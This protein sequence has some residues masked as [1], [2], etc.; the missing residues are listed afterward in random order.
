M[1]VTLRWENPE[2][3]SEFLRLRK[4]Y[5]EHGWLPDSSRIAL[6]ELVGESVVVRDSGEERSGDDG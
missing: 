6:L 1:T 2:D 5:R 4:E 3:T